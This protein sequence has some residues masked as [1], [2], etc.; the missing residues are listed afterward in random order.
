MYVSRSLH[1]ISE[2]SGIGEDRLLYM[3]CYG[4]YEDDRLVFSKGPVLKG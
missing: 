2:A 3:G 4:Y 1:R